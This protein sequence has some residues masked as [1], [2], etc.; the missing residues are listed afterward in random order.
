[1][2]E[3]LAHPCSLQHYLQQPSFGNSPG[4]SQLMNG[5]RKYGMYAQWSIIKNKEE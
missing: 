3:P 2:I 5:L 4:T 1:M